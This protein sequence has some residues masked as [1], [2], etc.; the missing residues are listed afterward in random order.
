[1]SKPLKPPFTRQTQSFSTLFQ[2]MIE[3]TI[4]QPTSK[5]IT[6]LLENTSCA[7]KTR[8]DDRTCQNH[9]KAKQ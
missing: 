8:A 1:V 5:T 9:P 4:F 3:R 6:G 7:E 2:E